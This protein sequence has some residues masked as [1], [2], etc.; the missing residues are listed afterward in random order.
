MRSILLVYYHPNYNIGQ[1]FI[2]D[3]PEKT[4]N[5]IILGRNPVATEVT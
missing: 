1:K 5:L 2:A 3:F 4:P